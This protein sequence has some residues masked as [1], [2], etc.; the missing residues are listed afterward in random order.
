MEKRKCIYPTPTLT[1]NK[2]YEILDQKRNE[3]L[4]R[5]DQKRKMWVSE[6]RFGDSGKSQS[7]LFLHVG[8]NTHFGL[9]NIPSRGIPS[10][11]VKSGGSYI[12]TRD[13]YQ[14]KVM[15]IKNITHPKS[16]IQLITIYLSDKKR[17]ARTFYRKRDGTYF[18]QSTGSA[19]SLQDLRTVLK[20]YYPSITPEECTQIFDVINSGKTHSH[21]W[22]TTVR[23]QVYHPKME[24]E[25]VAEILNEL[26]QN[27]RLYNVKPK[28]V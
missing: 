6:K 3:V 10:R 23:R 8:K 26:L 2:Y 9:S 24:V 25:K 22:C 18:M 11:L 1:D 16:L 12:K 4:I 5:N 19:R 27:H 13:E 20:S 15:N 7:G 14:E 17:A 21:H 28:K